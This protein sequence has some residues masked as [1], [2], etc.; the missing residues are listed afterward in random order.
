MPTGTEVGNNL[1]MLNIDV[2]MDKEICV[3]F[4]IGSASIKL[5]DLMIEP[6]PQRWSSGI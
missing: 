2:D 6:P 1:L 3:A 5:V 4:Q